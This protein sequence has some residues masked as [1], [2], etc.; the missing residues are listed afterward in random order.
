MVCINKRKMNGGGIVDNLLKPFTYEKYAGERHGYSLNPKTFL[1]PFSYLGPHT[2]LRE[3]ERRGDTQCVDDLDTYARDHDY[4]YDREKSEYEKDHDKPKHIRNVW[5]ADDTFIQKA[6]NS[7]DEPIMGPLSAKLISTKKTLE[8]SNLLDT[9]HFEGFGA[10]EES[11]DPVARLRKLAQKE[12]K[13]EKHSK[14]KTIKG[15]IAFLAPLAIGALSGLAGKF[16]G[17]LYDFVKSKLS[18]G[19]GYKIKKHKTIK[20]KVEFLREVVNNLK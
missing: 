8:K 1:Q 5:K 6:K 13:I 10:S 17:D 15:G 7:R 3:R 19:S 14:S 4:A 2:A 11:N 20:E 9:R 16:A 12:N 18:S